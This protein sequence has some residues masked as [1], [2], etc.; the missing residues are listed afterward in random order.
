MKERINPDLMIMRSNG[1]AYMGVINIPVTEQSVRKYSLM[2]EDY[3]QVNFSLDE[4]RF[5]LIGDAIHDPLFGWFRLRNEQMPHYNPQT[6]GYDYELR[7]DREHWLAENHLFMLITENLLGDKTRSETDWHLTAPLETHVRQAVENINMIG[8]DHYYF[9]SIEESAV[10]RGEA[11]HI[12]YQGTRIISALTMMANEFGC[13]WWVTYDDENMAACIHFGKCENDNEHHE[14]ENGVNVESMEISDNLNTYANRLYFLGGTKNI[15]EAYRRKLILHINNVNSGASPYEFQDSTRPLT[16]KMLLDEGEYEEGNVKT[17][18]TKSTSTRGRFINVSARTPSF[19][20]PQN[21]TPIVYSDIGG[22]VDFLLN[23]D[24]V[25]VMAEWTLRLVDENDS[26]KSTNLGFVSNDGSMYYGSRVQTAGFTLSAN[27]PNGE[28]TL[29][30]ASHSYHLELVLSVSGIM[31]DI[32][33]HDGHINGN[34]VIDGGKRYEARVIYEGVTYDIYMNPRYLLDGTDY[35]HFFTFKDGVPAGFGNGSTCELLDFNPVHVP[36]SYYTT[37]TDDP[38]SLL[39]VG[40]RRLHLPMDVPECENGYLQYDDTLLETQVV[41]LKLIA[42]N[43]YPR[44]YL[45]VKSVTE[46]QSVE[47]EEYS[48]GS[49]QEWPWKAYTVELENLD[50]TAFPFKRDYRQKD[51]KLEILFLS[52]MDT[53]KAYQD[54]QLPI[55]QTTGDYLLAGMTFEVDFASHEEANGIVR[56]YTLLRNES[57]GAKLPNEIL[58]PTVGDVCV[59]TGWEVKAMNGLGLMEKAEDLLLGAASD[60]MMGIEEGQFTFTC[61]MMSGWASSFIEGAPLYDADG[62]NFYESSGKDFWVRNDGSLYWLP[63][64]GERVRIIHGALKPVDGVSAKES[65]IIGYEMKLDKPW[66]SP[67]FIV[68]E[69]EAYSRIKQMEKKLNLTKV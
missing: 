25:E 58:K 49:R 50:G 38:S 21:N 7:F 46:A 2:G 54:S 43:I 55:P 42:D 12:A 27:F 63:D 6:S 37:E 56:T 3:I 44:C 52:D 64:V 35:S 23:S 1:T 29:T 33:Y 17:F 69:T 67:T 57:Y 10:H 24:S 20:I 66:D 40:E 68:G 65:R 5:F 62:K 31:G 60:Y 61:H 14:F 51:E 59:L 18:G 53:A 47:K 41:E 9:F 32:A 15:S 34:I 8:L 39:S 16:P 19:T 22:S 26:S 11:K 36:L 30:T 48:D 28:Y 4:P 13:E 45:R